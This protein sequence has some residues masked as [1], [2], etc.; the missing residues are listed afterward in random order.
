[1]IDKQYGVP[2]A[3]A[4][5][6]KPRKRRNLLLWIF[7]PAL[8]LGIAG[9]LYLTSGR[10]V[11]TDNA[12]TEA[13]HVNIAPQIGGRVVEVLVRENQAVKAGDV[14]FRIDAQPLEIAA[15]RMQAQV[16]SI[17]GLLNVARAGYASAQA[18]LRSAG[19]T[20]R[21][22]ERQYQRMQEMRGK[23]L[24]AQK[25]LDDAANN[26]ASARGRRDS[27]AAALVKAQSLLGGLPDTP[28]EKLAGFKLAQAQFEQTRLDL[29]HASVRAPMDGVIGKTSLQPGDFLATG[30]AAMP[31]VAIETLWVD[32]NFKE[33]DLT[34]VA[35]GQPAILEVDT[36]PGKK[37]KA[38]VASISPASGAEFSLLPAQNAT[39][40][41]VKIVQRI[42]VRL[43]IDDQDSGPILRAGMSVIVEIDTGKQN[44]L[45][46][47]IEGARDEPPTRVAL[48]HH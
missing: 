25:D 44:S 43:A 15:A 28:D 29:D 31:L 8:V 45:L 39:G 2:A 18:D 21:V 7:G 1:M 3:V 10:Y 13:D 34:H 20:L 27:D 33:T 5:P 30:Q 36:Y 47:R 22:D 48:T 6:A 16:D 32:A 9:Y 40:N 24:I 35:I 4:A 41:W 11:S 19:E 37:W 38:H 42:S 26:Y 46:G 12:Y 23:G 17:R 14:L